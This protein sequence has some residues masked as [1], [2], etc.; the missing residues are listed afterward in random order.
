ML[1][2]GLPC[3]HVLDVFLASSLPPAGSGQRRPLLHAREVKGGSEE[4]LLVFSPHPWQRR[5][6]HAGSSAGAGGCGRGWALRGA[7]PAHTQRAGAQAHRSSSH[8]S[9]QAPDPKP[10]PNCD[11]ENGFPAGKSEL[12]ESEEVVQ[13]PR[14]ISTD[15]HACTMHRL[16]S[17]P[18]GW[19]SQHPGAKTTLTS[20]QS[21][22]VS[23]FLH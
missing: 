22:E 23:I 7:V 16:Q 4:R 15:Y 9:T 1:F 21:R 2:P 18:R 13:T 3:L 19:A 8:S 5:A 17:H 12:R 14:N 10:V 11:K 6:E 20:T